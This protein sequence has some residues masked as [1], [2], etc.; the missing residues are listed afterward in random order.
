MIMPESMT[1]ST[2]KKML[3]KEVMDVVKLHKPKT[4]QELRELI[5]VQ[6]RENWEKLQEAKTKHAQA[7]EA[8]VPGEDGAADADSNDEELFYW[9]YGVCTF[10]SWE[11]EKETTA[12]EKRMQRYLSVRRDGI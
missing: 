5:R 8:L 4:Y 7:L 11:K 3:L 9:D 2:V 12:K 1:L 6:V 10:V